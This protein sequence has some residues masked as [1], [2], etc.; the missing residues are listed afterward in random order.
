MVSKELTNKKLFIELESNKLEDGKEVD[1]QGWV[2]T[3]RNNGSI[4]FIEF[5]DGT[6]FKNIQLVYDSSN[7]DYDTYS[8]IRYGSTIEV[9]GNIKLTP[10]NKQPFEIQVKNITLL[11]DCAEDYPLQKKRHSFE[12]LRDI[13]HLRPRSNTFYA[14]YRVRN[15]LAYAI[16]KYFQER[17]F[18]YVNTPIITANDA[19]GAGQVFKVVADMKHP[20]E[21]FKANA[22]LTVSGQ[23]HVESFAMAYKDVYTFGPT[24]R[25]ENSNTTRHAAEFWMIEPEMAFCDLEDNMNV[26]ESFLKYVIKYTLDNCK[27]EMKFFDSFIEKGLL[28]KIH[29]VLN[30]EFK[31]LTYTEAIEILLKAQKEGH[32]FEFN[33]IFWGMD[34]QSEH[35]RYITEQVFKGPV[36]LID[37]PKEIKAFYMKLNKDNKTVA[38]CDLLVPSV[39]ELIGGSQREEDYTKLKAKMDEIGNSKGLEWYLDLRKYGGCIHSGFGLGFDRLLMYITGINNI[40][41]VQPYPRTPGSLKF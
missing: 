40:R 31:R 12:F 33:K 1:L 6:Y 27:E 20:E 35:E 3:N 13:A 34:L 17:N 8:H 24:F 4:G 30:S 37:Y 26:I 23:L 16:H 41:D 25:A 7:K 19:E 10:E 28:D 9:Q 14:V 22:S 2:R 11:N 36:F 39:G 5:N 18:V 32:K 15:T 21:F 29:H 38:A